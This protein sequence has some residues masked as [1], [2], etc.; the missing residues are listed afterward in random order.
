M[1]NYYKQTVPAFSNLKKHMEFEIVEL[2]LKIKDKVIK[3]FKKNSRELDKNY[4]E[5]YIFQVDQQNLYKFEY[6]LKKLFTSE[7]GK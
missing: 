3:K 6:T 5:T 4:L 7:A 1:T 2:R